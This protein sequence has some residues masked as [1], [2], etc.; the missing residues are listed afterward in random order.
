MVLHKLIKNNKEIAY[1]VT[2][3]GKPVVLIHGFGEDHTIW[4]HQA[5]FLSK[6]FQLILPDLP[7]SGSSQ[8]QDDMSINA[9]GAV[10]HSIVNEVL[11]NEEDPVTIIGHSMGGYVALAFAEKYPAKVAGI[12]LFHSTAYADSDE[13]IQARKKG[14][15]FISKHGAE[16]FLKN[17]LTD[18]FSEHTKQNQPGIINQLIEKAGNFSAD[19]LV[20]YYEAMMQ[21]TDRSALLA[22]IQAPV[23]FIISENDVAIPFADSLRQSILPLKSYITILRQSGHMGMLE[24]PAAS[25]QALSQFL[26]NSS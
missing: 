9:M 22:N 12:G 13:K 16:A 26:E 2:G 17:T 11:Q 19:A 3:N 18:L 10:V 23:L 4:Q 6:K 7:G 1:R 21:R 8:L 20:S 15:S 14:I 25:N 24:E 5:D